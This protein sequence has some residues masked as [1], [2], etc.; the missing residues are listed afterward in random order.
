MGN[1]ACKTKDMKIKRSR[2]LF[3]ALVN[4]ATLISTNLFAQN[5]DI[6][7]LKFINPRNPNSSYWKNT[8][9]SAYWISGG[10]VIGTFIYGLASDNEQAKH[11]AYETLISIGSAEVV[12]ELFK[13][14]INRTRPADRYPD[15][16]FVTSPS[17]KYSFP[18]GH[19][20]LAFSTATT[21]SLQYHKW[22]VTV[23]AYL[24]AGT[25]G[26]S[27]MYLGRHY[28]TDVLAGAAIGTGGGY[29][30]HWLN[31]KIFSRQYNKGNSNK[32]YD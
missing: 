5:P 22:Y 30:G 16:V 13:Y 27:R 10:A 26:Y 14:T 11:N 19:T 20:S 7:L 25:V 15:E 2:L 3:I 4:V 17:H 8:S 18:S 29:F 24:W 31:K 23:P 9:N 1:I 21:L 32:T 6:D 12:T 28:P